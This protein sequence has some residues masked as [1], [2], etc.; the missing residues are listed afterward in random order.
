MY[1]NIYEIKRRSFHN[2]HTHKHTAT[3]PR[4]IF[5]LIL[6]CSTRAAVSVDVESY[7]FRSM[8]EIFFFLPSGFRCC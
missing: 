6:S 1:N 8:L 7:F 2:T 3:D 4:V 5:S